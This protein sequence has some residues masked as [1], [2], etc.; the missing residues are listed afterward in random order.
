MISLVNYIDKKDKIIYLMKCFVVSGV[1]SSIYIL[2]TSDFSIITRFGNQLTNVNAVGLMIVISAV[3]SLYFILE[4]KKYIY[5]LFMVLN[6]VIILLTGSRKSLLFIGFAII[7]MLISRKKI[8]THNTFKILLGSFAIFF[9]G[10]YIINEVPIFYQIIGRRM[11]NL[12]S[13]V[14]GEGTKE[15]SINIRYYMMQ[16]G[17]DSFKER[18]FIGYGL[19]NFRFLFASVPGGRETYAHNNIIELLVGIGF[20]GTVF[21]YISQIIV[22]KNLFKASKNISKTLCYSFLAII[23]GYL[24]MSV[25]L[26]YYYDKHISILL[27]VGSA[28]YRLSKIENKEL[29]TY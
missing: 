26:V 22:I 7:I 27:A 8:G 12:L 19:N 16:V 14:F 10:L 5:I 20:F 21:Y 18:P 2:L 6:L 3:F 28:I 15:G 11:E 9:I 23:L 24:F 29:K 17:F 25:G 13:F 1:V 4:E